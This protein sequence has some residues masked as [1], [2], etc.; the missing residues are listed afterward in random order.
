MQRLAQFRNT[1][2]A[3]HG[4][5]AQVVLI[6]LVVLF[7]VFF[8]AC[9][10]VFIGGYFWFMRMFGQ[11]FV[12]DPAEIRKLTAELAEISIPA[13]FSP[14]RAS[15]IFGMTEVVYH[16]CP[17]GDC[18]TAAA[19][20]KLDKAGHVEQP[21]ESE[22][23]ENAD[24]GELK[25]TSFESGDEEEFKI[26]NTIDADDFTDEQLQH[27][28]TTFTKELIQRKIQGRDCEFYIV[29]GEEKREYYIWEEEEIEVEEMTPE[30]P[31]PPA[32]P[33]EAAPTEA[34]PT[35]AT[36]PETT[37]REPARDASAEPAA[38]AE[39][40]PAAAPVQTGAAADA[41]EAAP[42][43]QSAG[44]PADAMQVTPAE[45]TPAQA[46]PA[47]PTETAPQTEPPKTEVPAKPGRRVVWVAGVFPG[48]KADVQLNYLVAEENYD[49]AKVRALIESIR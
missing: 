25:F 24:L 19:T 31:A 30:E 47:E 42:A 2:S 23:D 20:I 38:D 17:T 28:F 4:G 18:P 15:R 29:T 46:T 13:E 5:T 45:G 41:T 44:E 8:L 37:P 39:A 43:A 21:A 32:S 7:V 34:A 16:W 10:G 36:S 35:E 48:K 14:Y 22:P 12:T 33:T 1:G 6:T 40:A 3:R 27:R 26:D 11:A 9:A 49:A